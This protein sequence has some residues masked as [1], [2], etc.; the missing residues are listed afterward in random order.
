[1]ENERRREEREHELMVLKI[2]T[3]HP[4]NVPNT[5]SVSEDNGNTYFQL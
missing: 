3:G 2:I 5:V 1:L 4:L